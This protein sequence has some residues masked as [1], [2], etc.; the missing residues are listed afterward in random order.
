MDKSNIQSYIRELSKEFAPL[1][2]KLFKEVKNHIIEI[3]GKD[4]TYIIKRVLEYLNREVLY[5]KRHEL[6]FELS[7]NNK[8]LLIDYIDYILKDMNHFLNPY[9]SNSIKNNYIH[10]GWGDDI[11]KVMYAA[12]VLINIIQHLKILQLFESDQKVLITNERD[13]HKIDNAIDLI[14]SYTDNPHIVHYLQELKIEKKTVSKPKLLSSFF[15]QYTKM[16]IEGFNT[17]NS[18]ATKLSNEI[19]IKIFESGKDYRIYKN[20]ETMHYREFTFTRYTPH[21]QQ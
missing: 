9:V 4:T 13:K 6:L 20:Q 19:M 11:G 15:Y 14:M 21:N 1:D 8:E 10:S 2:Y 5:I 7:D 18:I 3:Y 17:N 16:F 12:G